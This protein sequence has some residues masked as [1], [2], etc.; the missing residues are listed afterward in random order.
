MWSEGLGGGLF[1]GRILVLLIFWGEGAQNAK[2]K[3]E[4][5]RVPERP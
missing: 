3:T 4:C 5:D 1:L 2:Q